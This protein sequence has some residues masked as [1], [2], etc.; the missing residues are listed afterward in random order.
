MRQ[1]SLSAESALKERLT[2]I[3]Q[4]GYRLPDETEAWPL[5]MQM[6]Q[7]LGSTDPEL[8]DMLIYKTLYHWSASYL[9]TRQLAEV[10]DIA[11]DDQHLLRG[12]GEQETDSVFMRSFSSLVVALCVAQHRARPFMTTEAVDET[13]RKMLYYLCRERD[14]R[15]RVAGKGWAHAVAHAADA[16]DELALCPELGEQALLDMLQVVR[17]TVAGAQVVFADE[18]DER[19]VTAVI[20]AIQRQVVTKADAARWVSGFVSAERPSTYEEWVRK[21]SN[22]KHFLRSLYF[23][24]RYEGVEGWFEPALSQTLREAS[25]HS[26]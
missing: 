2:S 13:Q 26:Y 15:G 11:L 9:D 22:I 20:S 10:L 5:T 4:D 21:G 23:R 1:R 19:L 14:L 16:L 7:C 25:V 6:M 17:A 12:L 18:E 3:A 8:R 24:A